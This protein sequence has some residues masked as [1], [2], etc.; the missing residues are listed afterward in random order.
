MG[1]ILNFILRNFFSWSFR[2]R[3]GEDIG[4]KEDTERESEA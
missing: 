1:N 3:A 2:I 4:S